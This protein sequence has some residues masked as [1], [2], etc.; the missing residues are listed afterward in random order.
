MLDDDGVPPV[1]RGKQVHKINKSLFDLAR[2]S[3]GI[4]VFTG[5]GV[6]VL[7]AVV[8]DDPLIPPKAVACDYPRRRATIAQLRERKLL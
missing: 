3:D 2:S 7:S 1:V 4:T 6:D 5:F 8:E